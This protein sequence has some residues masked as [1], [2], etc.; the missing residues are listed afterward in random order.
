[1]IGPKSP[2]PCWPASVAPAVRE[3]EI[4]AGIGRDEA[5]FGARAGLE[6]RPG[7]AADAG[8]GVGRA[9]ARKAQRRRLGELVGEHELHLLALP[10]LDER[11]GDRAGVGVSRR[12]LGRGRGELK[13]R[14]RGLEAE[15]A[16]GR[17]GGGV[18]P[19]AVA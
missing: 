6:A 14:R 1:M 12:R 5:D 11:A 15:K 17:R 16:V 19:R 7:E 9:Q 2:R 3:I 10:E 4:E 18:R 13:P 8:G